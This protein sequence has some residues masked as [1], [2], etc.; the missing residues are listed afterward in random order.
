MNDI[1]IQV[2]DDVLVVTRA[3]TAFKLIFRK[4]PESL[5]LLAS[6]LVADDEVDA[7]LSVHEFLALAFTAAKR[8]ARQ[9]GWIG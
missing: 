3:G 6:D 4:H 9:L 1:E 8:E 7:P 2:R 5:G